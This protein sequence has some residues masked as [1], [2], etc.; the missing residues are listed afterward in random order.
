MNSAM[1]VSRGPGGELRFETPSAGL[2]LDEQTGRYR[3]E[4][5]GGPSI[6]RDLE[7]IRDTLLDEPCANRA[8]VRHALWLLSQL[9]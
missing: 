5:R 2:V 7:Q 9:S 3:L 8:S 1:V 4:V 6:A